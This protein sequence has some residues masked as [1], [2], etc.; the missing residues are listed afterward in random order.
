MKRNS[1]IL[2]I[3]SMLA[4]SVIV[5]ANREPTVRSVQA[6]PPVNGMIKGYI[7]TQINVPQTNTVKQVFLPDIKVVIKDAAGNAVFSTTTDLDGGYKTAVLN[8]GKYQIC[9]EKNG[10]NSV[11]YNTEVK[12]LSNFPGPLSIKLESNFLYGLVRMKDSVPGYFRNQVFKTNIFT[13]ITATEG[14][15]TL[16]ERCN[17]FGE[18]IFAA[19]K[20]DL[21]YT[22]KATCQNAVVNGVATAPGVLN[23]KLP[24]SC[25][26]IRGIGAFDGTKNVLRTVPGKNLKL[27][28]ETFDAEG[29]VLTYQWVG[30]GDF[31]GSGF[32]N[33]KQAFWQLPNKIGRY[34]VFL[35]VTD[36]FGGFAYL[37]YDV[38]AN[39]G[40]INFSGTVK[41]IDGSGVISKASITVNGFFKT[42]TDANGYFKIA[43][44]EGSDR[45]AILNIEKEGYALCSKVYFTDATN[46]DYVLVKSTLGTFDP[47]TDINV[48]EKEDTFTKFFDERQRFKRPAAQVKI[49]ANSIVDSVGRKVTTPVSVG[50]RYVNLFDRNDLM[51]GDYG[52]VQ[53]GV[54]KR[55]DSYG[56]I[57]VQI[58]DKTNPEKR[59]KLAT[60]ATAEI[61][62]PLLSTILS[63]AP[64]SSIL[65]DYN[66]REGVWKDIGT[67]TKSGDAFVGKTNQF[68]TLNADV[69]FSDATCIQLMDNPQNALFPGI[70]IDVTITVPTTSGVPKIKTHTGV[71]QADLPYI[72]VRLP[73]NT[74]VQ[75]EVK[76]AGI[77]ISTQTVPTRNAVPGPANL[78]P[79]PPYTYCNDA[80][81]MPPPLPTTP[82]Q[83]FL[84]RVSTADAVQADAYYTLI[85]AIA[86]ADYNLD[87]TTNSSDK[88]SFDQWKLRNGFTN[89]LGS[90]NDLSDVKAVYFNAGDLAFW[91]GMHQKT[92]GSNIAYYVSNFTRDVDAIDDTD[93]TPSSLAIATVAMEYSPTVSGGIPITKFYVFNA[94]GQLINNADLDGYGPRFAPGLCITCHGGEEQTW[95]GLTDLNAFYTTN[96]TAM[97]SF[98]PFDVK[99]FKFSNQL[100]SA[101]SDMQLPIRL[102]N[103]K[104]LTTYQT[105]AIRDYVF[106]SYNTPVI[107]GG[108]T[109]NAILYD[110]I[111]TVNDWNSVTP[112]N[113][114]IPRD[115]YVNVIGTS[116]RTCHAGRSNSSLWFDTQSS[117][118]S[119]VF[120]GAVCGTFKYMPNAKVTFVNFWTDGAVN[121]PDQLRRYLGISTPCN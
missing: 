26:K 91:R 55:L 39:D 96:P 8:K 64:A 28:A 90:T 34:Q 82:D 114:I 56:A 60:G 80:Y 121:R 24:N 38:V 115:L 116:C 70:P 16:R 9:L 35:L 15:N 99:S 77:T 94:A 84:S 105:Q 19:L 111:A 109:L 69:A 68:S 63:S 67:L 75:I 51:P 22:V 100:G 106:A 27:L 98:L 31:P 25:P 5:M 73:P 49:P 120:Q 87:G 86:G 83:V 110:E 6:P 65:W 89:S 43:V 72:I 48:V 37:P 40:K 11:C 52:A 117:V 95:N 61:A 23:L 93:G 46:R 88:I 57:D 44:P 12:Q 33:N 47:R 20:R 1:I 42:K 59:Y 14:T 53:G 97:P 119:N 118:S 32:P 113:T 17:V 81:L 45:R 10:Y 85:G 3:F 13:S 21:R 101:K 58:R 104:S 2:A 79:D 76:R 54:Q 66:E 92:V 62:I 36:R 102:L 112:V 30:L 41:N 103:Q 107:A 108:A 50:I 71:T 74:N 78:N 7:Y 4:V 29:Q 18:Y